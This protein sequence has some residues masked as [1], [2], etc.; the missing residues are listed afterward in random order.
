VTTARTAQGPVGRQVRAPKTAELIAAHIRGQI[1]RA[2]LKAG[3]TLPSETSLME[4]FGVSRPTL[5][6][7]FRIL[8]SES[9]ITVRRGS[10]GG[11][12]VMTPDVAVA[13]RYVGLLLQVG[14]TTVADVYEA[15]L[16]LEPAA[17]GMLAARRTKQDIA[18]L[19]QCIDELSALVETNDQAHSPKVWADATYKFHALVLERAGNR[20][21]AM[22]AAMLRE[23]VASHVSAV[24]DRR[25]SQPDTVADFRKTVRAYRKLVSLIE[26]KD[27]GEA[28]R[29]WHTHMQIAGRRLLHDDLG[30]KTV[31]DLFS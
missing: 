26:A 3:Q 24:V 21:L 7:A 31:I 6:E 12:Q 9:L 11:A 29:Y 1:V 30:S 5:R 22:L 10:R 17:A 27:A 19:H 20:T 2:E 16:V 13:A 18:D 4:Q 28:E 15:R 8:E 14:G 23:V 25:L